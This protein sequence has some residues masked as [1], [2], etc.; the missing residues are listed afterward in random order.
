MELYKVGYSPTAYRLIGSKPISQMQGL[1]RPLPILTKARCL[2]SI[3]NL[4]VD[5][6][7][8]E[9]S[10]TVKNPIGELIKNSYRETSTRNC[11]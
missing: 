4:S 8:K 6:A 1:N 2:Y 7:Y 9:V 10:N 3:G 11:P 5:Q